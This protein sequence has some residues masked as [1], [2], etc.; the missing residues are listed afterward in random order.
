MTRS[1]LQPWIDRLTLASQYAEHA[2][3][4]AAQRLSVNHPPER[5]HD[6]F[7]HV[8]AVENELGVF[9]NMSANLN[10]LRFFH[11]PRW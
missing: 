5:A 8:R 11:W 9:S 4:H 2:F 6:L 3:M 10:A 1:F 7:G